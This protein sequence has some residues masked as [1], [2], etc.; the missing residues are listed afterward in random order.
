MPKSQNVMIDGKSFELLQSNDIHPEVKN[1]ISY[2]RTTMNDEKVWFYH[3][4]YNSADFKQW[5]DQTDIAC[6]HDGECFD[7][8]PVPIVN[9]YDATTN[10]YQVYG[11]FCSIN[12]AKA[13]I[14][15]HD[16]FLSTTQMLMFN[17]MILN[18]FQISDPVTPAPPRIRLNKYGGDLSLET[19]RNQFKKTS[20]ILLM[21]P[22]APCPVVVEESQP[23]NQPKQVDD[24]S[25]DTPHTRELSSM[26]EEFWKVHQQRVKSSCSE[27]S[28]SSSSSTTSTS[29]SASS[30]SSSSVTIPTQAPLTRSTPKNM[31]SIKRKKRMKRRILPTTSLQAFVRSK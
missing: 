25:S 13:Y 22:F 20:S 7:T 1:C 18:V 5:P 23:S 27:S 10:I 31:K 29:S 6:W 4:I 9:T 17:H 3:Q 12:C 14:L 30:S 11:V 24:A 28:T 16:T 21:P 2:V 8:Q 15:E 26:Y 19:F